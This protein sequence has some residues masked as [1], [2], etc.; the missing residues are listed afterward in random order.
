V[1]EVYERVGRP[2]AFFEVFPS[3][4]FPRALKKKLKH[5]RRLLLQVE[6]TIFR[7]HLAGTQVHLELTESNV[8]LPICW[9]AHR[10]SHSRT[11]AKA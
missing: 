8:G 11:V 7:S 1:V 5:L 2:E 10:T 9:D 3:D 6:L 4:Q